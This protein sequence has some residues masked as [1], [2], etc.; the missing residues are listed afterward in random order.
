[1]RVVDLRT[2]RPLDEETIRQTAE[3]CGR[4]IV[5]TE[6]RFMGGAG[7]TIAGVITGSDTIGYM[8]APVKV[9]TAIDSRVA[10]G[11]D[12]DTICLPNNDKILAAVDE[13]LSY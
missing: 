3:E 11:V 9:V 4:I 1:M 7:P 10:Y 8:E 5:L 13:V 2:V 12:G 6:D